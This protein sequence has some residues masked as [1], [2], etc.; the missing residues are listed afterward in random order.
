VVKLGA[1]TADSQADHQTGQSTALST[2]DAVDLSL[3]DIANIVLLH[4]EVGSSGKGHSYLVGLNGTRS[5][6]TTSSGRAAPST[7]RAWRRCPA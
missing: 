2:S 5:G 1:L 4:S 7:R 3:A 6:P